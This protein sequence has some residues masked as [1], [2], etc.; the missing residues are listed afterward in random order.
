MDSIPRKLHVGLLE[1]INLHLYPAFKTHYLAYAL[2]FGLKLPSVKAMSRS[3]ARNKKK[4]GETKADQN[5]GRRVRR[6]AMKVKH[7]V[8]MKFGPQP[9]V[10]RIRKRGPKVVYPKRELHYRKGHVYPSRESISLPV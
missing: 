9:L 5:T 10:V 2:Q 8:P 6:V 3:E 7:I 4:S 1:G